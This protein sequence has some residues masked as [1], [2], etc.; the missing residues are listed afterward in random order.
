MAALQALFRSNGE[1]DAIRQLNELSINIK[2][3]GPLWLFKYNQV[4]RFGPLRLPLLHILS[5]H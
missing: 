3:A 2:K 1:S 4:R 5:S